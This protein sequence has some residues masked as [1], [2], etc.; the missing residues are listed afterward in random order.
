MRHCIDPGWVKE[1]CWKELRLPAVFSPTLNQLQTGTVCPGREGNRKDDLIGQLTSV[2]NFCDLNNI[3]RGFKIISLRAG[4]RVRRGQSDTAAVK[5]IAMLSK[6]SIEEP[7][8]QE[9]SSSSPFKHCG[10]AQ[11]QIDVHQKVNVVITKAV[12]HWTKRNDN[13]AQKSRAR[14]RTQVV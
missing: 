13:T 9:K 6:K 5:P 12:F 8:K 10:R 14:D 11:M 3:L 1:H 4:F 2:T 7:L